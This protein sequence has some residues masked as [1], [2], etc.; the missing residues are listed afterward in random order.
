VAI[1]TQY[2]VELAVSTKLWSLRENDF[3]VFDNILNDRYFLNDAVSNILV[4]LKQ[5][6][7]LIETLF[8]YLYFLFSFLLIKIFFYE[9]HSFLNKNIII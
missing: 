8:P 9:K 6:V 5:K 7:C 3:K 2:P 4:Y 1:R